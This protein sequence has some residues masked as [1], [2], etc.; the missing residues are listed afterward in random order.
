VLT[1]ASL[2]VVGIVGVPGSRLLG[3][4]PLVV[5]GIAATSVPMAIGIAILRHHLYDIDR[6]ISRSIGWATISAILV[7]TFALV[8]VGLQAGLA[9]VT[10]GETVAV[11]ASTL[12]AFT[13]FQ[14]VRRRVQRGVDR[15]FDR[16]QLDAEQT[17]GEFARRVRD[18]VDL[19]AIRLS[20][21][22]SVDRSVRPT[23]AGVWLRPRKIS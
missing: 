13:L 17:A 11:A 21:V 6:I 19:L 18:Q 14:P 12:V 22:G 9:A 7:A 2:I 15:L 3:E 20:L 16:G 4:L 8:V 1:L 5:C 10:Q 23:T